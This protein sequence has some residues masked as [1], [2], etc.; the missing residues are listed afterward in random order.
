[1]LDVLEFGVTPN[2]EKA[3]PVGQQADGRLIFFACVALTGTHRESPIQLP[4]SE[5][6]GPTQ[7]RVFGAKTAGFTTSVF[8]PHEPRLGVF[9]HIAF[10]RRVV[11]LK[12]GESCGSPALS[13]SG[14]VGG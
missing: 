12:M 13:K 4:S 11:T 10:S 7:G 3:V 9:L 5:A 8:V 2:T 6:G 1:M 14:S